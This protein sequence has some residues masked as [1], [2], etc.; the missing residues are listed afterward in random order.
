MTITTPAG[1]ATTT[2]TW[3]IDRSH[4]VLGFS[5]KHA[6]VSK[7]RGSFAAFDGELV[8]DGEHP[9][10]SRAR[11]VI[12]T[13]SITTT[14]EQRDGH[15]K[16]ADFLDVETFPTM[17]FESTQVRQLTDDEFEMVGDLTIKDVTRPVTIAAELQGVSTAPDGT[18]KIGFEGSTSFSR[19]DFGLS[20]NVALEAGGVLVGDKVTISLDVEADLV[21]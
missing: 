21:S 9:E 4:T 15:L 12:E 5:A 10:N 20:W 3:K 11:L 19:K 13:P 17:T 14:N 18:R 16:S 1:V 8:L 2:G 6:M 7:V